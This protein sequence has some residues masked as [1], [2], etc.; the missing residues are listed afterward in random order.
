MGGYTERK[1]LVSV[2]MLTSRTDLF[3]IIK[4]EREIINTEQFSGKLL[5]NTTNSC[6]III[7]DTN[8]WAVLLPGNWENW[9]SIL[10]SGQR[11]TQGR[12]LT[13]RTMIKLTF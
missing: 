2:L 8:T 1:L 12:V 11:W 10:L 5:S 13:G 4:T 6:L 3:V 9:L 7:P